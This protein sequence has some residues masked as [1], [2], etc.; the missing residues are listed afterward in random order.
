MMFFLQK[1]LKAEITR[2]F[3]DHI[4]VQNNSSRATTPAKALGISWIV[5]ALLIAGS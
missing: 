1:S 3:Y 5:L 2:V 4:L